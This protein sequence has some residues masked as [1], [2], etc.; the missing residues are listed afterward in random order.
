MYYYYDNK[1]LTEEYLHND[2]GITLTPRK[3]ITLYTDDVSEI[4]GWE[5]EVETWIINDSQWYNRDQLPYYRKLDN[6]ENTIY[7]IDQSLNDSVNNYVLYTEDDYFDYDESS[8]TKKHINKFQYLHDNYGITK[9]ESKL[10]LLVNGII[11][12]WYNK[13]EDQYWIVDETKWSNTP[14]SYT[15]G[16]D[17]M[18]IGDLNSVGAISMFMYTGTKHDLP[19]GSIVDAS[20]LKPINLN[21]PDSGSLSCHKD[22]DTVISGKW[23]LLTAVPALPAS[24]AC[25]VLARKVP[26]GASDSSDN[27]IKE[28]Q[29]NQFIETV[30]YNL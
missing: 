5:N 27:S 17:D 1:W 24:N 16:S 7:L 4:N 20:V 19:Y 28:H 2:Y 21:F 18:D 22:Y 25:I 12:C 29:N 6:S 30:E 9:T 10:Y 13:D 8:I 15:E 14:P 23:R 11:K 26:S 3:N